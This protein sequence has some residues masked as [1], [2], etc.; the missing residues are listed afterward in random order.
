MVT[1]VE[2]MGVSPER[3]EELTVFLAHVVAAEET[4]SGV[5]KQIEIMGDAGDLSTKEQLYL[6]FLFGGA[7]TLRRA[8]HDPVLALLARRS[9]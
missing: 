6:A 9:D 1:F 4:V 5:M 8:S 7:E 3:L 2:G